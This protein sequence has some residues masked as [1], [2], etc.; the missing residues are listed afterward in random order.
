MS[1]E[2]SILLV[3]DDRELAAMLERLLSAEGYDVTH[4]PDGQRALHLGLTRPFDALL[5]DRGLPAIEGLDLLGKLRGK[6]VTT[7]ALILSARGSVADRI[8]GLD[9]GAEDYLTKP[10]DLDELLARMRALLR[11]HQESAGVLSLGTRVL[12]VE[13]RLVRERSSADGTG[14]SLSEREALLLALLA[15]RPQRVFTRAEL[16][17]QVFTDAESDVAVDTYVHYC[18]RKLGRG[19]IRTVRGIGYQLGST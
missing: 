4:A 5:V 14:I 11:R 3:E 2:P 7:P 9:A 12:D 10:F 15:R 6:G 17:D 18:R 8:E 13:A 16:L 19:V 1:Q